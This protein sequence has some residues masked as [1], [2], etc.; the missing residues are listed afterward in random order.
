MRFEFESEIKQLEGKIKWSVF[1]FPYSALE[2]FGSKGNIPVCITVD[3]HSFDHMLLPSKNGHYLVYNEFIRQAVGKD[4]GDSVHITLEKDTKKREIVIPAYIE[5]VLRDAGVLEV[6]QKQ[7]DYLK[8]EQI[9]YIEIA[10]KEETRLNRINTLTKR[11][12]N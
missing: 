4:L 5:T 11:L 3:G 12:E 2:H 7:P 10:K 6:F 8:R 1:Y 9:N